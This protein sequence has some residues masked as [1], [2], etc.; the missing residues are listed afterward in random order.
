MELTRKLQ[1]A[2]QTVMAFMTVALT[3]NRFGMTS[4]KSIEF[5]T[6]SYPHSPFQLSFQ[7]EYPSL[8]Q[9]I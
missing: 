3:F 4:A 2:A 6:I 9:I 1:Y 7:I 8:L 5:N